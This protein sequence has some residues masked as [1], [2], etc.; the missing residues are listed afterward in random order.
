[1]KYPEISIIIPFY[2]SQDYIE[3]CINSVLKQKFLDFELILIDDGSTDRSFQ[4]ALR[5]AKLDDRIILLQ[6]ENGGQGSARNLGLEHARGS[7]IGFVDS[8]DFIDPQMYKILH[9]H[10][11]SNSADL[12]VCGYNTFRKINGTPKPLTRIQEVILFDNFT[13]MKTYLSDTYISGGPCNKLYSKK[14]FDNV[15]FPILKMREDAYVMPHIIKNTSKAVYV[16]KNLYNWF[17]REGSTE[18][19]SFSINNLSALDSIKSLESVVK[20]H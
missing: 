7:F 18:R 1:M 3:R 6:K 15:R 19:S 10:I 12:A 2:N 4:I 11:I 5:F 20:K 9:E 13:L 8:D 17:L 14:L 16:G